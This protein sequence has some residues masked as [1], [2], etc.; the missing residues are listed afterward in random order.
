MRFLLLRSKRINP[1]SKST[2]LCRWCRRL[3]VQ[4]V[5]C[6]ERCIA[7]CP[8]TALWNVQG[9]FFINS[10]HKPQSLSSPFLARLS[11]EVLLARAASLLFLSTV[12]LLGTPSSSRFQALCSFRASA[13]QFSGGDLN[14]VKFQYRH[15]PPTPVLKTS[16]LFPVIFHLED[17]SR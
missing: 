4:N 16:F 1:S 5:H 8:N 7:S 10:A 3:R 9:Q 15:R 11:A 6:G 2:L 14:P 13:V 17:E 12:Q